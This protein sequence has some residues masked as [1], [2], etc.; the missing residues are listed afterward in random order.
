MFQSKLDS[1]G[2]YLPKNE[3]VAEKLMKAFVAISVFTVV[4]YLLLG[5]ATAGGLVQSFDA[6]VARGGTYYGPYGILGLGSA[7]V[8]FDALGFSVWRLCGF[9]LEPSTASGFLLA[10]SF[11]SE[12]IFLQTKKKLW[13]ISGILCFLGGGFLTISNTAYLAVGATLLLGE[14]F[15]LKMGKHVGRHLVKVCF[16]LFVITAAVL[17]RYIVAEYY[18]DNLD[19]RYLIGVRDSIDNPYGGRLE[20]MQLNIENVSQ[21]PLTKLWGVGFRTPGKDEGLTSASAPIQWYMYTGIIGVLLLILR[22][23]QLVRDILKT[24]FNSPYTLRV[25]QAWLAVFVLN[26][27]YGTLMSPFYFVTVVLVFYYANKFRVRAQYD[28]IQ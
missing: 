24:I 8:Y 4:Q 14:V 22:E 6:S 26:L 11:F 15:W 7:N 3:D 1:T 25:S 27:S 10:S 23:F 5:L 16:F 9:W 2:I 19:L 21:S 12:I 17:G 18:G 20:T 28:K 13:K